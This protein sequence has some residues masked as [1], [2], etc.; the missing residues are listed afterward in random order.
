[1]SGDLT[2]DADVPANDM[3]DDS[4]VFRAVC[5]LADARGDPFRR[6]PWWQRYTECTSC[7]RSCCHL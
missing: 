7:P 1:M 6:Q 3:L 5:P 2:V 4:R